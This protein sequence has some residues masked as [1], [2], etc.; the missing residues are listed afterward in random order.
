MAAGGWFF[1]A[2]I[3]LAAAVGTFELYGME[4]E[5]GYRPFMLIGV[6]ASIV[7]VVLPFTQFAVQASWILV[8]TLLTASTGA[9]YLARPLYAGSYL[10][11]VFTLVPVLYV[12]LMLGHLSLLRQ[13]P[14]GAW[15]VALA[16]LVTWAY[17]TGAFFAGSLAGRRPFMQHVSPSKTI[18][19]VQGGLALSAIAGLAAAPMVGIAFWQGVLFGVGA[20]IV[21][22]LGD[23]M[24]SMVKRQAGVKDSGRLVPGHGGLLD[25]IDSLLFTGVLTYYAAMLLGHAS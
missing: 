16:L 8:L 22:Q 4:R 17:D 2:L 23:L 18:E 21:A 1:A 7:I 13:A 6:G 9:V 15:W 11:W 10:N 12:G 24:E 5:M 3:A 19:G 25:R 20:G 14:A